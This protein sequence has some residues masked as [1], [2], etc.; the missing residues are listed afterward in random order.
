VS[1][2]LGTLPTPVGRK[3]KQRREEHIQRA[4]LRRRSAFGG[5]KYA[6]LRLH[7]GCASRDGQPAIRTSLVNIKRS[8]EWLHV[9]ASTDAA[10]RLLGLGA[11]TDRRW[12]NAC[13]SVKL[14]VWRVCFP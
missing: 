14:F 13:D 12:K 7:M 9:G 4:P 3:G 2:R 10:P 5:R 1:R 11:A 8:R 6:P